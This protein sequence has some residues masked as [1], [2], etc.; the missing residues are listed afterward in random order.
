M[1][2]DA[3]SRLHN[4]LFNP[5]RLRRAGDEAGL[6]HDWAAASRAYGAYLAKVPS[7]ADI[8]VQFGHANKERGNIGDAANA[9]RTAIEIASNDSDPHLHLAALLRTMG[10]QHAALRHYLRGAA[11][12]NELAVR[13]VAV[14]ERLVREAGASGAAAAATRAHA[15]PVANVEQVWIGRTATAGMVNLDLLAM[16]NYRAASVHHGRYKLVWLHE[17]LLSDHDP[18]RWRLILDE[19]LRLLGGRG[20][21]KVRHAQNE[22]IS[23]I[24]LRS[25]LGRRPGLTVT[26]RPSQ[27]IEGGLVDATFEIQRHNVEAYKDRSWSFVI[28]AQ[29]GR[30]ATVLK[31]LDRI[32]RLA[33]DIPHEVIVVGPHFREYRDRAIFVLDKEYPADHP[34][35]ALKKNDA[36]AYAQYANLCFMHDRYYIAND[37]FEGFDVFGYDFDFVGIHQRYETGEPY[38]F[39]GELTGS[40]LIW[41]VPRH[42][43]N[44]QRTRPTHFVNGGIM[45]FK[46]ETFMKIRY[47]PLLAWNEGEDVEVSH[48]FLTANL[49]PRLNLHSTAITTVPASHTAVFLE[50]V[51]D[52]D[53]PGLREE[54]RSAS[55]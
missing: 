28:L 51:A 12:G 14:Q 36:A 45:V 20:H 11:L 50:D 41:S 40:P 3:L 52:D 16:R 13:E 37:F 42:S 4:R 54:R 47:N 30:T 18:S 55:R 9:Y 21:L 7:D 26:M 24:A 35:I 22:N 1:K 31:M 48:Q 29:G 49:P 46:R 34:Q 53:D 17:V 44:Y 25:Y 39:Y 5:R 2:I 10:D 27:F 8:W 19:A 43:T 32:E 15:E 6:R 38:P 23:L 33:A